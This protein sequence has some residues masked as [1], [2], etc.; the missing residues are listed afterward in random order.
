MKIAYGICLSVLLAVFIYACGYFVSAQKIYSYCGSEPIMDP[1]WSLTITVV[2]TYRF[3][4]SS[5][6]QPA[7]QLDRAV[8]PNYWTYTVRSASTYPEMVGKPVFIHPYHAPIWQ[9]IF[10]TL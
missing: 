10:P 4:T 5:L 6:W 7:H 8:R 2:P 3:L 9:T 1:H